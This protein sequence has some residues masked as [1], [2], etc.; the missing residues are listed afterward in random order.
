MASAVSA[1]R[2]GTGSTPPG[3]TPAGKAAS[4]KTPAGNAFNPVPAS[5]AQKP[6]LQKSAASRKT[7]SRHGH[8]T[9]RRLLI[10]KASHEGNN[11]KV[12]E[13]MV[14]K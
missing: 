2:Q 9:M 11:K 6:V 14:N 13:Q 10:L 7:V 3:S 5:P 1:A 4:S 12:L 8:G